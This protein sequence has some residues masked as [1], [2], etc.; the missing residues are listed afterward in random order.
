MR[1]YGRTGKPFA[2]LYAENGGSRKLLHL[3][4]ASIY[5]NGRQK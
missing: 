1:M 3:E 4:S 5:L 2:L